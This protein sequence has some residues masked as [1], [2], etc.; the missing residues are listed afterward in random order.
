MSK[1]KKSDNIDV[2]IIYQCNVKTPSYRCKDEVSGG[3]LKF[4][5]KH[6][7]H[8]YQIWVEALFSARWCTAGRWMMR[9]THNCELIQSSVADTRSWL[10]QQGTKETN[11][12]WL[13]ISLTFSFFFLT[14]H[15]YSL[16]WTFKILINTHKNDI[17]SILFR[18]FKEKISISRNLCSIVI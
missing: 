8:V 9:S 12:S 2:T 1:K 18:G 4:A 14:Q 15:Y 13:F 3:S 17:G 5:I 7:P 16:K 10:L 6:S 11:V